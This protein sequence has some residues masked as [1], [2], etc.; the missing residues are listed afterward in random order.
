MKVKEIY[1][2]ALALGLE[3]PSESAEFE[4]FIVPHFNLLLYEMFRYNNIARQRADKE[5]LT[6][7]PI[8]SSADEENPYESVFDSAMIYGLYA[9]LMIADGDTELAP[10]YTQMYY[11]NRDAALLAESE[12]VEDCYETSDC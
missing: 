7:V 6:S 5:V 9:K 2:N 1:T 12:M 3:L 8:I 10:T 11:A 4:D